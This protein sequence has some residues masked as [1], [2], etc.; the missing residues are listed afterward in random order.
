M[1][2][3]C[4]PFMGRVS[5]IHNFFYLS[6]GVSINYQVLGKNRFIIVVLESRKVLFVPNFKLTSSL[7]HINK[8]RIWTTEL[9]YIAVQKT[10]SL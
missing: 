1:G 6:H 5:H 10:G 4:L 2:S 3:R 7:S 9:V 8:I